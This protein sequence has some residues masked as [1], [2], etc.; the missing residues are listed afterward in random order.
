MHK[1]STPSCWL[2]CLL[3]AGLGIRP[4]STKKVQYSGALCMVMRRPLRNVALERCATTSILRE[5]PFLQWCIAASVI[6]TNTSVVD[7]ATE[8]CTCR[9]FRRS[10]DWTAKVITIVIGVCRDIYIYIYIT[11]ERATYPILG[12][13]SKDRV[14]A[15]YPPRQF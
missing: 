4:P 1:W 11:L 5:T 14:Q 9:I 10:R 13:N 8:Q 6:I 3:Q 2:G 7:T 15:M 12:D